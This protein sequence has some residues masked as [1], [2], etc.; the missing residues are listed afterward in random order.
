MRFVDLIEK[1]ADGFSLSTEE[2]K[3]MVDG[4]VDGTIPDY[5]MSAMLMAIVQ[6]D[7]D[8][9]ETA[10]LTMAMMY[11]GDVVDLSDLPGHKLDKHS[12]GGV[13]DTTTLVVAP[14]VAAC[15]GT[16]AKMS[17]R[18]LGHTGGTL[19][20]LESIPGTC[21]EQSLDQFREIVRKCGL[22][23]IGQTGDLDPADRKMYALRD[24]TATVRSIPLIASSIMSKKLA[25]GADVIVLDVK[26]GTGAFMKTIDEA[27]RLARTMV[28]IGTR[29]GR[30]VRALITD[31]NQPL[32]NAV[33]NA[34]EVQEA[35]ELLSGR[36]PETDPLYE[37][38]M[39]L[40]ENL[41]V[42][43]GIAEN[44]AQGRAMLKEKIQDGSG[45]SRLREMIALQ[46][47]DAS[48]LS[49][50]NMKKLVEVKQ[51]VDVCAQKDGYVKEMNAEKIGTAAQM[52]GAGRA[53]KGD[54][55]DPAV[56]LVMK[57]RC[58]AKV[59]TGDPLCTLYVNDDSAMQSVTA[60]LHEAIVIGD[61]NAQVQPMIHGIITEK[62]I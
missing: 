21:V 33:G 56:G 26:T 32:G 13:G 23:V 5:Q 17:G 49:V 31:M 46:G 34:L 29:T 30:K 44:E 57:V 28:E 39:L 60:L 36:I 61:D 35:V 47:G 11:S 37:V 40:G 2:I 25:S 4:F 12:T 41:L 59:K 16:V 15:G 50:E 55:I 42:L 9:R 45:L 1:K 19:D 62:D 48:Y 8:E 24:V 18:G 6:K 27:K 20:K 22:A 3:Y 53:K 14:L 54:P 58:G 51:L 38:C 10:D 52:L 7:M 43:A